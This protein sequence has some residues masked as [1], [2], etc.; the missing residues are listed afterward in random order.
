MVYGSYYG[1]PLA[2]DI[3]AHELTHGVTQYNPICFTTTS[4]AP[5][6]SPSQICGVSITIRPT[7]RGTTRQTSSGASAKTSQDGPILPHFPHLV[8]GI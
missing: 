8:C 6:A 5:S 1:D 2:D 3:V 7:V 4:Q